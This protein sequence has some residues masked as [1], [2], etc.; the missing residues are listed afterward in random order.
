MAGEEPEQKRGEVERQVYAV[1]EKS[2]ALPHPNSKLRKFIDEV[3]LHFEE[4]GKWEMQGKL[5]S[6]TKVMRSMHPYRQNI[7]V[8]HLLNTFTQDL[9]REWRK[10]EQVALLAFMYHSSMDIEALSSKCEEAILLAGDKGTPQVGGADAVEDLKVLATSADKLLDWMV[11]RVRGEKEF[12][13]FLRD[14]VQWRN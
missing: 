1:L 3:L 9:K 14:V 12:Q 10:I 8:E 4:Q 7:E 6:I 13:V 11:S 2:E 5:E